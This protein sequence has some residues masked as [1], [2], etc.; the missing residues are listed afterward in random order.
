MKFN[1]LFIQYPIHLHIT[2]IKRSHSNLINNHLIKIEAFDYFYYK[3]LISKQI[4]IIL[5][6]FKLS[7]LYSFKGHPDMAF[8]TRSVNE[9]SSKCEYK[10]V[11][12][13]LKFNL[14]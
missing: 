6:F 12:L 13:T 14:Y 9:E 1:H 10:E 5:L 8:E 4:F 3:L 2:N 11:I 7:I